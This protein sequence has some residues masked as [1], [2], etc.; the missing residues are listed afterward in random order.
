MSDTRASAYEPRVSRRALQSVGAQSA[1][2]CQY[3]DYRQLVIGP[4]TAAGD[5][6]IYVYFLRD[7]PS[8]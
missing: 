7:F 3:I 6:Y 1:A 2:A 5:D 4:S 8:Q